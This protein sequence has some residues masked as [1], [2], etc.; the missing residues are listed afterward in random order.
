MKTS[1]ALTS[2]TVGLATLIRP[3]F[4]PGLL[5]EDEDLT[6]GV[7]YTRELN[8]LLFRSLFGCG[9]ICG[10]KVS[11]TPICNHRKLQIEVDGG[12][13]LD[14]MGDPIHVPCKQTVVFDPECNPFPPQIWVSVCYVEKQCRPRDVSCS[15]EDPGQSTGQIERTRIRD[16]FEI[17]LYSQQPE[18]ACSCEERAK[19][20]P[21]SGG[22]CCPEQTPEGPAATPS[23]PVLE[24]ERIP[25]DQ[26]D[27]H[28]RRKLSHCY[29]DHNAGVCACDC[30]GCNC[31]LLARFDL[32]LA[33]DGGA[34]ESADQPDPDEE[35]V[36]RFIRPVLLGDAIQRGLVRLPLKKVQPTSA[37]AS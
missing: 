23:P 8:R 26:G 27:G 29:D 31:V 21:R 12:L 7:D 13:A 33:E 34:V 5:L 17:K 4:S 15:C 28:E 35:Q 20:T 37:P 14:C 25:T 1:Q 32:K 18:C 10:L 22:Q 2:P 36:V 30:C 11:A 19:P 3:R 9:V 16:G 6:A 24:S